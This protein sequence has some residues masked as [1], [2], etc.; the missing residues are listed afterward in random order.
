MF[1]I[2]LTRYVGHNIVIIRTTGCP[3]FS[4]NARDKFGMA[5]SVNSGHPEKLEITPTDNRFRNKI[6]SG[7]EVGGRDLGT[8]SSL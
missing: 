2:D 5:A 7:K 4:S 1:F 3:C 8:A 6:A